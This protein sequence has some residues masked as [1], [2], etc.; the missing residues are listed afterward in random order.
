MTEMTNETDPVT[1]AQTRVE[2]ENQPSPEAR[3]Q[4]Q[5]VNEQA[6]LARQQRLPRMVRHDI[7]SCLNQ[8]IGYSDLLTDEATEQGLDHLVDDLQ[9]IHRAGKTL[10][11]LINDH[12]DP[13]NQRADNFQPRRDVT[14]MTSGTVRTSAEDGEEGEIP[15][16]EGRLLIVDDSE[17]N[18]EMLLRLLN[19]QGYHASQAQNGRQAL[20]MLAASPFDLVLLDV[21]LPEADGYE[22]LSQIRTDAT[23]KH[24]PVIMISALDDLD[25]VVRGIEMGAEDYLPRPVNPVLLRA[26]ISASLEQKRLRDREQALFEQ[27]QS[28][29]RQLQEAER[30]RDDLTH[31]IVHDLRTPLTSLL[32]GLQTLELT[33]SL[34]TDQQELLAL[35]ARGGSTLLGMVNDMLDISKMEEQ[36][37]ALEY[38][39]IDVTALVDDAL[40]QVA[41]LAQEHELTLE[42]LLAPHLPVLIADAEKLRRTLVNLLGNAIKFTPS[43]GRITLAVGFDDVSL[44]FSVRDTGEGI[45]PEAFERIFEKF[46]QVQTRKAG[47]RMS[48]GLG[49]TFCKL[50]AEVHGGRIWV[51]STMGKGS[52]FSVRIPRLPAGQET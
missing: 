13:V 45:P 29:Y 4:E 52:V 30:M 22:V 24:I 7:R 43:G 3:I 39:A 51:E 11:D 15:L 25:S 12:V 14:S 42:R 34:T 1:P 40:L 38:E 33:D 50:V 26:R 17:A 9:K 37:L 41:L 8:I 19:R 44:T 2:V 49:L 21:M 36:S 27:V 46:G 6:A 32:S 18:R 10:L 31:M 5:R 20:E 35:S 47:Y 23:L 48:T 16:K 28:S